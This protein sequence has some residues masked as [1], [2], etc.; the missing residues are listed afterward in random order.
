[1]KI[2]NFKLPSNLIYCLMISH[3]EKTRIVFLKKKFKKKMKCMS[4]NA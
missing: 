2:V 4:N 3:N 1:M